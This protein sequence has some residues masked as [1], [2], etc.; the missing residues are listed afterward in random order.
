MD[1]AGSSATSAESRRRDAVSARRAARPCRILISSFRDCA[2]T[3]LKTAGTRKPFK[4]GKRHAGRT[5]YNVGTEAVS[6][7]GPCAWDRTGR[8]SPRSWT[9]FPSSTCRSYTVFCQRIWR[10]TR[11]SPWIRTCRSLL[12]AALSDSELQEVLT[13]LFLD[14]T[15][16]IIEEMPAIVVKRILQDL[17][18]GQAQADQCDSAV[19]GRQRGQYHDHRVCG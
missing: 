11:L 3:F 1:A 4:G 8:T 12:I 5:D 17:N 15:V 2:Y 7:G 18:G 10:R 6:R 19:S 16:D 14:D 9:K 13:L